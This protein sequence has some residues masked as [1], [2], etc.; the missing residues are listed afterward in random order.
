MRTITVKDGQSI[1]DIAVQEYGS[2]DGAINIIR[3]NDLT[4]Q[5]Y[6]TRL[7]GGQQLVINGEPINRTVKEILAGQAATPASQREVQIGIGGS[8]LPGGAFSPSFN[9]SFG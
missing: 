3:D 2:A 8:P 6:Q 1:F 5:G 7:V 9:L 4:A